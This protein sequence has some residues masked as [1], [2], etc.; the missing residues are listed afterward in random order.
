MKILYTILKNK[1]FFMFVMIIALIMM[2]F[3]QCG[4]TESAKQETERIRQNQIALTDTIRNYITKDGLHAAERRALR[5][6]I[7]ELGDSIKFE[8][9]KPPITIIQYKT[10]I[11]EK[12]VEVPV[13]IK[14][15]SL[16]NFIVTEQTDSWGKSNRNIKVSIPFEIKNDSLFP[17]LAS[18]NLNQNIWLSATIN[19]NKKTKETFVNLATDYPGV[20]FNDA[21]GI[22]IEPNDRGLRSLGYNNRKTLGIGVQLGIGMTPDRFPSPYVGVGISYTPK[23]LQW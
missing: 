7:K 6:T 10:V 11:Q 5:L 23:F 13:Y 19:Q 8:R 20:I 4:E 21:T 3:R 9:S 12:L 14:S 16:T 18:I 22:L 2:L 1:D 17:G 15:D